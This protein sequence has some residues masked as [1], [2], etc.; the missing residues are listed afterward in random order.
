MP[1]PTPQAIEWHWHLDEM[2]VRIAYAAA[3][4]ELGLG[5]KHIVGKRKNNRAEGS[6]VPIRLRER[7]MQC[8]SL[9]LI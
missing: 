5:A 9:D 4:C 8:I 7:K 2:F 6:H 1:A 3:A